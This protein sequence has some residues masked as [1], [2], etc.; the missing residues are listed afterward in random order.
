MARPSVVSLTPPFVNLVLYAGDGANLRLTA[1][2]LDGEPFDLRGDVRAQI[3][4]TRRAVDA[5]VDWE[6]E[7][8]EAG[9]GIL[10]L[11][12][13]GED[14]RSLMGDLDKFKG[15]WDCVWTM[16]DSEPVTL[17]QGDV[18]CDLDVTR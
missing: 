18:Q 15:V 16:V 1:F 9:E 6:V 17:I 3:R 8:A 11:R 4:Q 12:L 2:D 10:V 5:L 13:T 14:T 7:M